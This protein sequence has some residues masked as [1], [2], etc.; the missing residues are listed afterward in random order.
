M[1]KEYKS[2]SGIY[3]KL[4]FVFVIVF[5]LGKIFKIYLLKDIPFDIFFFGVWMILVIIYAVANLIM[6]NYLE[7]NHPEK[8]SSLIKGFQGFKFI[9]SKETFNDPILSKLKNEVKKTYL[10]C[11]VH[12]FSF[13]IYFISFESFKL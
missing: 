2:Y 5:F 3:W 13:P 4:W 11:I 6:S 12:F 8:W 9:L 7:K 10:L 1:N